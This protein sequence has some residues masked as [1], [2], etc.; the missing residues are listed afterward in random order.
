MKTLLSSDKKSTYYSENISGLKNSI[1]N[2]WLKF[3]C[4]TALRIFLYELR[5]RSYTKSINYKLFLH[6]LY[7]QI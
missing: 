4:S 6:N 2:I 7:F 1:A 3:Q 5:H